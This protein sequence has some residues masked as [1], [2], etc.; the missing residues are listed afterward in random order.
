MKPTPS[1]V[2]SAALVPW[3]LALAVAGATPARGLD[4]DPRDAF[5]EAVAALCGATFE[6]YSSFPAEPD[7]PFAGK[8]LV[9]TVADCAGDE[10]RVPF[11]VGDDRSRT[12]ILT[13]TS[14]GL[15]LQH[16]HRHDDGTPD[17]LTMYGGWAT[18][19]G[20]ALSQS[21]AADDYTI[22]LIPEAATNVWTLTLAADGDE[23]TYYL[24]RHAAPRFRATLA[25]GPADGAD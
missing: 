7:D 11:A 3:L 8:L 13:R 15:R 5:F 25:R 4:D 17:D 18:G 23:L 22:E 9:A 2:F 14:Q 6:G 10:I 20:S 12:W 16:D 21:F 19:D 1:S 24:E